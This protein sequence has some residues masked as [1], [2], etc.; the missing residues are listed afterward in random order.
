MTVGSPCRGIC[1]LD[2]GGKFCTSCQRTLGEIAGWSRFS[3]EEK[4]CIWARLLSLPLPV[5]EKSCSQCGQHFVCGSGGKQGGC[6]CQDLPN[7]APLAGSIGDCLCPDC[8]TKA[9]HETTK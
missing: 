5:K 2:A 1:Q 9:L 3:E 8:L 4:Q 7:Q 6:W